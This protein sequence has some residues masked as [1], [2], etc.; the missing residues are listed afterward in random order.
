MDTKKLNGN[1]IQ[2]SLVSLLVIVVVILSGVVLKM[3]HQL[4]ALSP[5]LAT[6]AIAA[7]AELARAQKADTPPTD[8]KVGSKADTK[9]D[10]YADSNAWDP[11]AE[12]QHMQR[13]IDRMFADSFGRFGLT[14][15]DD[16]LFTEPTFSPKIDL[17]DNKDAYVLSMDL[18]G[19]EAGNVDVQVDG[20][21]V[22]ISGER[23]NTVTEKDKS[24]QVVK[25]ERRT[26]TF[27]RTVILPSDVDA[28][29]MTAHDDNGVYT[30]TLPKL[31]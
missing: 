9:T 18:P 16:D 10:A 23:N 31:S 13:Q 26:G 3:S 15:A 17:Q 28:E 29:K 25:Q 12:M 8:T 22:T 19:V 6:E 1:W 30:V 5:P 7:T 27:A 14:P 11:F 21:E 20:R 4:E 24:G 2:W